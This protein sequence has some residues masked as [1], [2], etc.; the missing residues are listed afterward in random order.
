MG[1][2]SFSQSGEDLI[3]D[4]LFNALGIT[5]GVY[6]DVGANDPV[7]LSNTFFFYQ[8]NWRGFC[9]EPQPH[10][11]S[12]LRKMR[13][14][15]TVINAGIGAKDGVL[16]FYEMEPDTLS[17]FSQ[18]AAETYAKKGHA[19][20]RRVELPMLSVETFINQNP[21]AKNIDLLSLDIEAD[22]TPI[23]AQLI[24]YGVRPKVIVCETRAY[25]PDLNGRYEV[26]KVDA[27]RALGYDVYADTFINT[28]F[29][30][31]GLRERGAA[32]LR[33]ENA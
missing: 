12:R 10:L 1:K 21:E 16:M 23:V 13:S 8:R 4:Y 26:E 22:E 18:D 15:D 5:L 3:I 2:I 33:D 25:S 28:I 31:K 7:H 27:I 24:N 30:D 11:C 19:V 32:G 9:V 17:T 29:L 14:R 20:K 6:V